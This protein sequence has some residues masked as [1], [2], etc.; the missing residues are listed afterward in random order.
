MMKTCAFEIEYNASERTHLSFGTS[1][2]TKK[3]DCRMIRTAHKPMRENWEAARGV[4]TVTPAASTSWKRK[5]TMSRATYCGLK[6]VYSMY[7]IDA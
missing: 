6:M 7:V 5:A 4:N 2:P 3:G 1:C